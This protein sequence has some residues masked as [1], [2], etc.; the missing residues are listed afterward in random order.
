LVTR[1]QLLK[2]KTKG[3]RR[4]GE[5]LKRNR[6]KFKSK[7]RIGRYEADIVVGRL[8]IEIDGKVHK[9][10]NRDKD[11]YFFSKGYVPVHL[12]T[13]FQDTK[14]IEKELKFLIKENNKYG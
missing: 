12:S 6:I 5:I 7:W 14:V 1:S 8:I 4:I 11:I 10:T 3:E 13:Y 9:E 2:L